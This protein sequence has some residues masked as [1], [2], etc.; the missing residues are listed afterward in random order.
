MK[1]QKLAVVFAA[2]LTLVGFSSCLNSEDDGIRQYY[3]NMEVNP[4]FTYVTFS[5]PDGVEFV[6]SK[7]VTS[8]SNSKLA[9]IYCQYNANDLT[10]DSK[11]LSVTLLSD[12]VYLKSL[13][14]T[15]GSV[16]PAETSTV[17]LS[18][19]GESDGGIWGFNKYLI[20]MPSYKVKKGTTQENLSS[21]L[22][23]HQLSV[24]YVPENDDTNTNT[25]KLYLRYQIAGVGTSSTEENVDDTESWASDYTI[26]Y[27]DA[28]YVTLSNFIARYQSAH[29]AEP[30][31][32]TV[33]YEVNNGTSFP[34]IA[35]K[36]TKTM[37]YTL[38]KNTTNN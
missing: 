19:L 3:G 14:Y 15:G 1:K 31:K 30:E 2:L 24:Y 9:F 5:T 7:S 35:K 6:P 17:S 27:S 28:V 18:S 13:D 37:T 11:K 12:P 34:S 33:E 23:N 10:T 26:Q 25:L 16:L 38:Y 22:T 4:G 36:Q 20:L 29:G 8:S 32:I 21:E